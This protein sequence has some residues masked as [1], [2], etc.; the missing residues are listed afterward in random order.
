M[1]NIKK[2]NVDMV[3]HKETI[4]IPSQ[5]DEGTVKNSSSFVGYLGQERA[6][7]S[8]RKQV[9]VIWFVDFAKTDTTTSENLSHA[10]L[11]KV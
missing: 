1:W 2:N 4:L 10:I 11:L 5:F 9:R 6:H 8:F 3:I 7:R